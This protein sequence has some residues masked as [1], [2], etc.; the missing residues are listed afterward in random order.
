MDQDDDDANLF[1]KI[2]ND[3][4][5][6]P[7]DLSLVVMLSVSKVSVITIKSEALKCHVS[8][9]PLNVTCHIWS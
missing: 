2:I 6:C 9:M 3:E 5:D 4:V 1:Y 8:C 7:E